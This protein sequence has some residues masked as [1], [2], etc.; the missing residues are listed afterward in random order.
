MVWGGVPGPA[1]DDAVTTI[2][3]GP[4]RAIGWRAR[5]YR[6]CNPRPTPRRCR[7][8]RRD[9]TRWRGTSRPAPSASC[10]TGCRSHF[11]IGD[12]LAVQRSRR[13]KD[14]SARVPARV[15]YSYSASEGNRYRLPVI[16]ASH[17]TYGCA[18]AQLTST[19]G[20]R[21]RPQP[22]STIC[23]RAIACPRRRR[24]TRRRSARTS[25]TANGLAMV[26]SC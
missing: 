4:G 5:N 14:I 9:Q 24:P 23:G 16:L 13:P 1:A 22:K 10:P 26:T 20:R 17:V 12:G 2:A 3:A 7:P 15:E 25:H 21:P 18:S 11:A 6:Y 19:A 8:C